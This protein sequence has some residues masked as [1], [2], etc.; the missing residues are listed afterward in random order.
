[1]LFEYL[2]S[3]CL[4]LL[5][6]YL[7]LCFCLI[8]LSYP[9]VLFSCIIL[10]SY[11]LALFSCLIRFSYPLVLFCI[12]LLPFSCLI[13]FSHSLYQNSKD[14][15]MLVDVTV[16]GPAV[17]ISCR[18]KTTNKIMVNFYWKSSF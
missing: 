11:F 17:T 4:I 3:Y 1:M 9:P 7:V 8:L 10:L 13:L 5:P 14:W 16:V 12:I 15:K 18:N 2:L 6:S